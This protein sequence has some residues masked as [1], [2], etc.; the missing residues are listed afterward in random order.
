[1]G[2]LVE[3]VKMRRGDARRVTERGQTHLRAGVS[4]AIDLPIPVRREFQNADSVV[5]PTAGERCGVHAADGGST[6]AQGSLTRTSSPCSRQRR[7][8]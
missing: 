4:P 1:M 7:G 5:P 3:V 2:E 8:R 6:C